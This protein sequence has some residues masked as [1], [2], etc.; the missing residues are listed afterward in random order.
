MRRETDDTTTSAPPAK[1]TKITFSDSVETLGVQN[2]TPKIKKESFSPK[3]RSSMSWGF[4]TM[5]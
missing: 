2:G 4:S 5:I 1:S 3:P